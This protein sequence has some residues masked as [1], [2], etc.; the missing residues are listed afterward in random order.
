MGGETFQVTATVFREGHDAV[1][2]NVVLRDPGGRR[3]PWTPMRELA[4]GTDRWGAEVTPTPRAGGRTPSRR[5]AIRSPPGAT[6]PASRSRHGIDTELVLAEGAALYE[7]AA[8]GVPK[9]RGPRGGAR[10][11]RRAA[12]RG[13]ARPAT[14]SPPRSPPRWTRRS[15]RHPLR[16]LVSSSRPAAAAGRAP[17]GAVRVL[18]RAVP[19]LGGR[20][21]QSRANRRSAAPSAPRPSGCP[22]SP[23]WASTW[24]TCRRSTPSAPPTARAP[25]TRLTAG[26]RRRRRALGDRLGRRRPRR[27]PPRPRH[28]RGLRPLRGDAA[29][30]LRMEVALDFALQCSPDHPWVDEAP[31][32]VPPPRRTAR[33]RTPRTRRRSTRT[34]TRSPSTRTCAASSGRRCGSCGYWM[35]HG[36]RIFR[37]DNPH[38]KPVVFWEKVIADI[39]RTDPDVIFLAEAFTRPAMMR[40]LATVGFQQSYTYFT[41]RTTKQELT[42]YLTELS[43]ESAAYMRP[44]FFVNTPD[45][46]HALP[47]GGRPARLRGPRRARRDALPDLGR[48]R[49]D[50]SCARTPRSGP[51]A[52]STWT[53]RSTSCGPATGR[54][55]S[56]RAAP[57]PR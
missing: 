39:N 16:D 18:V 23:R 40:T 19:A 8:A 46:L 5:G 21:G 14:G 57:S 12:R 43:G 3:G 2:A 50:T 54:R 47:P 6:T 49:R 22:R 42:D 1:A 33:S 11:G 17:A 38:T 56:A 51:A 53:P 24:S 4:P 44:N 27:D 52:R 25:T 32:V 13:A 35:G 15:P 45:I 7:R 28:A 41:W 10:G 36:V 29:R 55:P 37:V 20:G 31:R 34:S 9:S 26:P 30:D 48:V